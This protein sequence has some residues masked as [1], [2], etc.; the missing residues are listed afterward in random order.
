MKQRPKGKENQFFSINEKTESMRKNIDTI[1]SKLSNNI[2]N[3]QKK[4]TNMGR[5]NERREC[6]GESKSFCSRSKGQVGESPF[7]TKTKRKQKELGNLL[8]RWPPS[9]T[10]ALALDNFFFLAITLQLT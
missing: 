10:P 5:N 1:Q 9:L 4:K 6:G 8:K 7:D 2:T 3:K